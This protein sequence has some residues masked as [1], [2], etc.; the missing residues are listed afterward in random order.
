MKN[1]YSLTKII[2]IVIDLLK[3]LRS[4]FEFVR[5]SNSLYEIVRNCVNKKN[6]NR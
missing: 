4:N 2:K 6:K 5:P 1:C 3:L